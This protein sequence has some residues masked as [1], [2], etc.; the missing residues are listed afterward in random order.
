MRINIAYGMTTDWFEYSYVAIASVLSNASDEDDYYFYIMANSFSQEAIDGFNKLKKIRSAEFE[1]ITIDDSYFEGAI[2]DW[3][4]VSSSYRLH[5]PSLVNEPK[6][7]YLDTD[8][9]ALKNIAE[10][11]ETDIS[12]YYLAAVEDKHG[13]LMKTRLKFAPEETFFNGGMQLLNLD[14]F[15]E[16]GLEAIIMQ[17]LREVLFYTDQDVINDVCRGKILSLPL[18]YNIMPVMSAYKTRKAEFL[19]TLPNPVLVHFTA[20]PWKGAKCAHSDKW[21]FYKNIVDNL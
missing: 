19:E 15:R 17:K 12:N 21:Y 5:L 7:L 4:G 6:I 2:H 10:L 20:K 11:Y 16:D 13:N 14:K 9:I 1:F 18:K 3:L 8:I